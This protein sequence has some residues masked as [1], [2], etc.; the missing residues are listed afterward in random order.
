MVVHTCNALLPLGKP[1]IIDTVGAG[2]VFIGSMIAQLV[3]A[4][5]EALA[6]KS[7]SNARL[8]PDVDM[9][10]CL[11]EANRLCGMKICQEGFQ[12]LVRGAIYL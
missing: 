1:T 4:H 3:K 11:K 5:A 12:D 8:F 9:E 7:S 2:D 6:G 10:S